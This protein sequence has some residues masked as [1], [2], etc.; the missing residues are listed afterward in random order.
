MSALSDVQP[1]RGWTTGE[2]DTTG[3]VYRNEEHGLEVTVRSV[4]GEINVENGGDGP[5]Q[6]VVELLQDWFATGLHGEREMRAT[7]ESRASAAEVAESFMQE[8]VDELETADAVEVHRGIADYEAATAVLTSETAA[9]ALADTAGYSDELLESVVE[10]ET[11][12]SIRLIA[13]RNG[14]ELTTVAG[15]TPDGLDIRSIHGVFPV[16]GGGTR[17]VLDETFPIATAVHLDVGTLYRFVFRERRETDVLLPPG[18]QV[19]SPEFERTVS[20]VLE[21]KW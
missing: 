15:D 4:R 7:T 6:Y 3:A 13:H 9:E 5:T 16:D 1:P 17:Q 21:E 10:A 11:G 20:N 2:A 8:F 19:T 18:T 14:D 12:G